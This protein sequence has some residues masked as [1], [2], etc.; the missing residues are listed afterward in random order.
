[1]LSL[2]IHIPLRWS[3]PRHRTPGVDGPRSWT[4]LNTSGSNTAGWLR[5]SISQR[6]RRLRSRIP[7]VCRGTKEMRS[8]AR[9]RFQRL[10]ASLERSTPLNPTPRATASPTASPSTSTLTLSNVYELPLSI[11]GLGVTSTRISQ[12]IDAD[13]CSREWIFSVCI[14]GRKPV[15]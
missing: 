8:I 9:T 11:C 1:M 13:S 15:P 12:S 7:S 4:S 10:R 6:W 14:S 2:L 3:P 5:S